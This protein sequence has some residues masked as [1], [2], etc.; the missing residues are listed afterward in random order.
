MKISR[1]LIAAFIVMGVFSSVSL[2]AQDDREDVVYL[3]NG[4]IYRGIIIEQVPGKTVKVE[5]IGGNVFTVDIA[6]IEKLTKEKKVA[7]DN[8]QAEMR[9][10]IEGG[11]MRG[12]NMWPP[13]TFHRDRYHRFDQFDS[14]GPR[15][16]PK[17]FHYR[18]KGYFFNAQLL[19]ELGQG[20]V[21]IING[22]KFSQ[23]GYLGIGVGVDLVG[24]APIGHYDFGGSGAPYAGTYLPLFVH[25]SGDILKKRITPYYTVEAGYAMRYDSYPGYNVFGTQFTGRNSFH[26]GGMMG[27]IGIGVKFNCKHRV[28]FNLSAN[29]DFQNTRYN[30][31][32]NIDNSNGM[33]WKHGNTLSLLT[34]GLK[35]GIGF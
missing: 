28:N 23:F 26:E 2:T 35:F 17:D 9:Y 20:G 3:K 13:H 10:P 15:R 29:A 4:N 7:K 27:G 8:G 34:P 11:E 18:D 14:A 1:L 21:R 12:R 19:G 32:Y 6:D 31:Y 5:T 30:S 25:Y 16:M 22:Y 24:F 33:T